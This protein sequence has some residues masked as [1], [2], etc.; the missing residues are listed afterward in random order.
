MSYLRSIEG[1]SGLC[2]SH[3]FAVRCKG[4]A[5]NDVFHSYQ[6]HESTPYDPTSCRH[7]SIEQSNSY[8]RRRRVLTCLCKAF[9]TQM[10]FSLIG[11]RSHLRVNQIEFFTRW[12][13]ICTIPFLSGTTLVEKVKLP[14]VRCVT[15]RTFI[16]TNISNEKLEES[17][18]CCFVCGC[19]FIIFIVVPYLF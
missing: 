5:P 1:D 19:D 12:L 10:P 6:S 8:S 18:A 7:P 14:M 2:N 9:Y 4:H 3:S 15:T 13:K 16:S 11:V 17:D